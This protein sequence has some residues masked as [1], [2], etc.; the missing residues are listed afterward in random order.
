MSTPGGVTY[1]YLTRVPTVLGIVPSGDQLAP[2][3][4]E[5]SKLAA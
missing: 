5:Y 3:S 4:V 2:L 1:V